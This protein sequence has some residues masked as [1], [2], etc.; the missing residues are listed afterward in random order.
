MH[1]IPKRGF[2]FDSLL[3]LLR[4]AP[5]ALRIP[6]GKIEYLLSHSSAQLQ[7]PGAQLLKDRLFKTWLSSMGILGS[8]K[9][10]HG[11]TRQGAL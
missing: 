8:E 1:A 6:R 7:R 2:S 5:S 4:N 9:N 3:L 10:W 11:F